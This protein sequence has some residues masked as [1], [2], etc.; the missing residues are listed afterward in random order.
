MTALGTFSTV[1]V[2]GLRETKY[3]VA[4]YGKD[5]FM[6]SNKSPADAKADQLINQRNPDLEQPENNIL[7]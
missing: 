1:S 5:F 7:L 4:G 2:G 3:R 6:R